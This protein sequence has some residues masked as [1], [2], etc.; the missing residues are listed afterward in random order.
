M[1]VALDVAAKLGRETGHGNDGTTE[2]TGSAEAAEAFLEEFPLAKIVVIID[3]HSSESGFLL[4]RGEKRGDFE[5]SP[6]LPVSL[7]CS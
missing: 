5:T 6:L 7:Y 1:E 3:T 4:W 2:R